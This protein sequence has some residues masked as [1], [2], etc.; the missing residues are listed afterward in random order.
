MKKLIAGISALVI[1]GGCVCGYFFLREPSKDEN[2]VISKEVTV[3]R[4]NVVAGVTESAAVKVESLEQ[5]Y[6]LELNSTSISA[7]VQ[8]TASASSGSSGKNSPDAIMNTSSG[9]KS[10]KS[11]GVTGSTSVSSKSETSLTR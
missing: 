3:Q 1:A 10:S 2:S 4:G 7:S 8:S 9:S 11:S 5:T 6:D